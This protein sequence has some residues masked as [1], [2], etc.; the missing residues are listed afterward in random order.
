MKELKKRMSDVDLPAEEGVESSETP[1]PA[2]DSEVEE[3]VIVVE[4]HQPV[5]GTWGMVLE[6]SGLYV[7]LRSHPPRWG[8]G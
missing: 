5:Q 2:Y 8:R 7:V 4:H 1:T 6:A 3:D